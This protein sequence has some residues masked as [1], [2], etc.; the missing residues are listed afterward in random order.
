[1]SAPPRYDG[2]ADWYEDEF[3]SSR[4]E[5]LQLE[6]VRRMLG[7]GTGTLLDIGCGTGALTT[8]IA[9]WG[10]AVRGVDVSEDMLRYARSRGLDVSRADGT[11]LP[12][13]AASFDAVVSM[14][15]HTDIDDFGGMTR[16]AAR[17]L[18]DEGIF[19][20]VGAHPCFVGPH[21]RFVEGKGVPELHPGYRVTGRYVE[22]PGITAAGLRVK[23]GATHLPLGRFLQAFFDVG[24]RLEWLEESEEREYPHIISL[25]C[26]R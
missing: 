26:R 8:E 9:R 19:V 23:V 14:W 6:T 1:M 5:E 17:V 25:R 15:T 7:E 24:F 10:W 2:I 3:R 4:L 16:E 18:R 21:S 13:E 20:Y 22:G 12:F 11:D